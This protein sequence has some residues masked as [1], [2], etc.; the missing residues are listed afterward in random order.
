M[1]DSSGITDKELMY[2]L[3]GRTD[4]GIPRRAPGTNPQRPIYLEAVRWMRAS[5]R[6]RQRAVAQFHDELGEEYNWNE[7]K[8]RWMPTNKSVRPEIERIREERHGPDG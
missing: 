8:D 1:S 6:S 5:T 3:Y 4:I 2:R 7:L